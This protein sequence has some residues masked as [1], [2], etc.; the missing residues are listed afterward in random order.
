MNKD[1]QQRKGI[2]KS[3]GRP[4]NHKPDQVSRARK[5]G[6]INQLKGKA[7]KLPARS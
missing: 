5:D 6:I 4:H 7:A 2:E 1:V 3:T